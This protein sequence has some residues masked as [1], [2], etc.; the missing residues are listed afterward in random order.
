M[1]ADGVRFLAVLAV[2]ALGCVI[3]IGTLFALASTSAESL[4]TPGIEM[5]RATAADPA[6]A[7]AAPDPATET[8]SPTAQ[9]VT[10]TTQASAPQPVQPQAPVAVSD[11][12]D[13][14]GADTD[15]DTDD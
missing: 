6:G 2:V 3:L 7:T 11:D 12:D 14:D 15:D 4:R 8:P 5:A 1:K 13:D 10:G 9:P